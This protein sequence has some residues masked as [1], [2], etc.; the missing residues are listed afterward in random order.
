MANPG[1]WVLVN[2]LVSV[3]NAFQNIYTAFVESMDGVR[4]DIGESKALLNNNKARRTLT[5]IKA[6]L[7][8]PSHLSERRLRT[9]RSRSSF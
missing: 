1:G 2:S 6:S 8:L 7:W 4:G 3:D 5:C 9:R